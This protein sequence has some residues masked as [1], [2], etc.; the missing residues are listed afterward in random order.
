LPTPTVRA[1]PDVVTFA[2]AG[3][4][5]DGC[6]MA[7]GDALNEAEGVEAASVTFADKR[8]VVR[9]DSA[10][11][12]VAALTLVIE[13]AGYKPSVVAPAGGTSGSSTP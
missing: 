12:N 4:H 5:C 9:F 6:A 1:E 10:K 2:I 8:A 3:M 13:K 11:T 7:I